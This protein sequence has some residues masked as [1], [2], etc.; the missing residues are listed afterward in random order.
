[1]MTS[2]YKKEDYDYW[3]KKYKDVC[4]GK[5]IAC[6]D[7]KMYGL[8]DHRWYV[9]YTNNT[10]VKNYNNFIEFE[11]GIHPSIRMTK[12]K[13]TKLIKQAIKETGIESPTEKE[14]EP[15][16]SRAIIKRLWGSLSEMK[17]ELEIPNIR[18]NN[19]LKHI[20]FK[21]LKIVLLDVCKDI[22]KDMEYVTTKEISNR[23]PVKYIT[24]EHIFKDNGIKIR[25]FLNENN[26]PFQKS[27]KGYVHNFEDGEVTKSSYEY[28][29]TNILRENGLKYK[30][31][32]NR[33][34]R[35]RCFIEGYDG[36]LDCDYVININDKKIYVEI[37]GMLSNHEKHYYENIEIN[38]KSLERYRNKLKEKVEMLKKNNLTYLILL[39]SDLNNEQK[40]INYI[41]EGLYGEK[42]Q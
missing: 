40:I 42:D 26:I 24:I 6:K 2:K 31:D 17:D 28:K 5:P 30:S 12:E 3:V 39:P 34:V 41:K 27:G 33:D 32:Y 1:M 37:A 23:A 35:Y 13:A 16:I 20:E 7:L 8:P 21:D 18:G 25:D 22:L 9:R 29:F 11:I 15:Y 14:L 38:S 19:L 10:K 4:C 36:Y